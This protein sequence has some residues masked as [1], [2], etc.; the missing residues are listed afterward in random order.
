M[1]SKN[2][3]CGVTR[4]ILFVYQNVRNAKLPLLTAGLHDPVLTYAQRSSRN[5]AFCI[6]CGII[7]QCATIEITIILRQWYRCPHVK[8]LQRQDQKN[9][10]PTLTCSGCIP[11]QAEKPSSL[12]AHKVS[13]KHVPPVVLSRITPCSDRIAT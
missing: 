11:G 9:F 7:V 8:Q 3:P 12:Q 2:R 5:P 6:L 4:D 1:G 10:G 13:L